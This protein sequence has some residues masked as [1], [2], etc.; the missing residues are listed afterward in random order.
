MESFW[1]WLGR[2][3]ERK[4]MTGERRSHLTF[5]VQHTSDIAVKVPTYSYLN[6][7]SHDLW[8][9]QRTYAHFPTIYWS[10]KFSEPFGPLETW[11]LRIQCWRIHVLLHWRHTS[12]T[13]REKRMGHNNNHNNSNSNNID[14]NRKNVSL[15]IQHC[16]LTELC[17][18]W[19]WIMMM[20]YNGPIFSNVDFSWNIDFC[21]RWKAAE[22]QFIHFVFSWVDSI[23][24]RHMNPL[25][26]LRCQS[27]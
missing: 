27:I 5:T 15:Q 19:L 24:W 2:T 12:H 25:W 3:K 11:R 17:L 22:N 21:A 8:V 7:F 10:N 14:I 26:Q 6:K 20:L 4:K 18:N 16:A 13:R 9:Q 1:Q 23:V